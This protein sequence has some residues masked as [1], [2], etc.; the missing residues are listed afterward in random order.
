[1][2]AWQQ[3]D[4]LPQVLTQYV[5]R[6]GYE[7]LGLQEVFSLESVHQTAPLGLLFQLEHK[8]KPNSRESLEVYDK[9][10]F[11]S[12]RVIKNAGAA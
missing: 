11:F 9:D 5:Q 7:Q 12:K 8:V 10:L 4:A 1:M 6:I 2:H 3:M